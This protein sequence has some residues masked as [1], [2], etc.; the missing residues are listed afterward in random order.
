MAMKANNE[1]EIDG[2]DKEE[3]MSPLKDANDVCVEYSI[4]GKALVFLVEFPNWEGVRSFRVISSSCCRH[5]SQSL[6]SYQ[7][8][9]YKVQN[10]IKLNSG[11]IV[12]D[13]AMLILIPHD[14][15]LLILDS[16]FY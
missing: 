11:L 9:G 14:N 7:T 2:E 12:S 3:K 4:E 5:S 1:V 6:R 15:N 16:I 10:G 8:S 13:L